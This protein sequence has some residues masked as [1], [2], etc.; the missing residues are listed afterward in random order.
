M[1]ARKLVMVRLEWKQL[2]ICNPQ[3][4]S[5]VDSLLPA[6]RSCRDLAIASVASLS[7]E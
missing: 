5:L 6:P 1:V 4:E 2:L 3:S 7:M